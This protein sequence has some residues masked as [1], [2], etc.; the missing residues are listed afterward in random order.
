MV[1]LSCK[2][3]PQDSW[4]HSDEPDSSVRGASVESGEFLALS[5]LIQGSLRQEQLDFTAQSSTAPVL[6]PNVQRIGRQS[7]YFQPWPVRLQSG[8]QLVSSR[9][10]CVD[11]V[12]SQ[13]LASKGKSGRML[14]SAPS[15]SPAAESCSITSGSG[16]CSRFRICNAQHLKSRVTCTSAVS[17]APG[18]KTSYLKSMLHKHWG[19]L[20]VFHCA[21]VAGVHLS[22]Y[23]Y[24][25]IY[26]NKI[27]FNVQ[28]TVK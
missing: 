17:V 12:S 13:R 27:T 4:T 19:P 8:P 22:R 20:G 6:Q 25:Y 21:V 7:G 3:D 5:N 15:G 1:N 23:M 10:K 14:S 2:D 11:V 16:S 18:S 28:Y 26:I 24:L 9:V